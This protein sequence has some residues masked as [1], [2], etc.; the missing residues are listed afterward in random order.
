MFR[1][2]R[3]LEYHKTSELAVPWGRSVSWL[4]HYKWRY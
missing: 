2:V 4:Y 3:K 1:T